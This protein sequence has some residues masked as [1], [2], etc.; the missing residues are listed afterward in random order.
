MIGAADGLPFADP[1]EQ[2]RLG[3]DVEEVLHSLADLAYRVEMSDMA[4]E[5]YRIL[6]VARFAA[7]PLSFL[8]EGEKEVGRLC[9]A[10]AWELR[11][12][13]SFI[14]Y[15]KVMAR[16]WLHADEEPPFPDAHGRWVTT[17]PRIENT[18]SMVQ[19]ASFIRSV[20]PGD[21]AERWRGDGV[22]SHRGGDAK[23]P[24]G[25]QTKCLSERR[26]VL[27]R[28]LGVHSHTSL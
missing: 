8:A 6:E 1:G 25:T 9:P 5:K 16:M 27:P 15:V 17:M 3:Q 23:E 2:G 11:L 13:E 21:T 10:V 4:R 7:R 28:P 18:P 22:A 26:G 20:F 14:G 12:G 24:D 19:F